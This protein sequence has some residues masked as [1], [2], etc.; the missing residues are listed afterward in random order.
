MT[1]PLNYT[2]KAI[3]DLLG[4]ADRPTCAPDGKLGFRF[5]ADHLRRAEV[6]VLPDGGELFDRSKPHG[7]MPGMVYK[8]PFPVIAVEY[9]TSCDRW[10]QADETA[11]PK[12]IALAWEWDGKM[13]DGSIDGEGPAPGSGVMI[14]SISYFAE[15]RLWMPVGG[16]M[17]ISYEAAYAVAQPRPYQIA[18]AEAGR[19]P[20]R[21]LTE[22]RLQITNTLALLPESLAA[23]AQVMGMDAV[24]DTLTRDLMDEINAYCDLCIALAC[25][26]V[27]AER[28]AQPERLNRA[29]IKA[30]KLP[31]K[32]F[33]VLNVAGAGIGGATGA[34]NG[35]GVRSHLRRGHV[36]RLGPE[37]MTWVNACMVNGSRAGFVD[38]A[39]AVKGVG[40]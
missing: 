13:P 10:M 34:G 23:A 32:D 11:C 40:K 16:A 29:R 30:G 17:L 24:F 22:R 8:P 3:E 36:R 19:I 5:L 2:T 1:Q 21:S 39:Y 15:Q 25:N 37:R 4:L 31:L 20:K 14:A 6:F 26:N 18:M 35:S 7:E 38:K 12:R 28:I 27:S 9:Q 33:H